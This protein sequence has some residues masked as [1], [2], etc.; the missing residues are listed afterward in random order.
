MKIFISLV[1]LECTNIKFIDYG[2]QYRYKTNLNK[3]KAE[4]NRLWML[5]G[6]TIRCYGKITELQ[7]YDQY[8]L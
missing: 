2:A 7:Y 6:I 5:F 1:P 3:T 4:N 8:F